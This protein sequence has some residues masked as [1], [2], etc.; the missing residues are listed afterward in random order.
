LF[1][2]T[3]F[4]LVAVMTPPPLL[5]PLAFR[6]GD[7]F[8]YEIRAFRTVRYQ[9]EVETQRR[10]Q[11]VA[12]AVPRQY[13]IDPSVRAHWT[14]VLNDL[15]ESVRELR[16]HP[17]PLAEKVR[18]LRQRFGLALP[19]QVF[20]TLLQT[21]PGNLTLMRESLL[22]LLHAEWQRG[23]KPTAEDRNE[24]LERVRANLTQ[25]PLDG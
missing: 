25:L 3:V 1:V 9:S 21:S 20:A 24:A 13:R 7:L 12:S 11:E 19:D 14:A 23:I 22:R 15:F 16:L 2:L 18:Q 6:E 5:A 17:Q 4:I 8:P 10:R